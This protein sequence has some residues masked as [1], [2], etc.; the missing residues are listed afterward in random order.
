MSEWYAY[1]HDAVASTKFLS[2][3]K[4]S[5]KDVCS[6][7]QNVDYFHDGA[8][9]LPAVGD[10]VFTDAAMTTPL[11]GGYY[12]SGTGNIEIYTDFTFPT[13]INTG[14]VLSVNICF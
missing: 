7:T 4:G 3:L 5:T 13:P 10:F 6:L 11:G 14:E 9:A 12:R 1:D 2:S 8:G